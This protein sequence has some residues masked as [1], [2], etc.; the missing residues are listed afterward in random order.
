M[1][2]SWDVIED[3]PTETAAN[4]RG[5]PRKAFLSK[6]AASRIYDMQKQKTL[7]SDL[8]SGRIFYHLLGF[9]DP[10]CLPGAP[11]A[12]AVVMS[13]AMAVS[14]HSKFF[15]GLE[16]TLFLQEIFSVSQFLVFQNS[17]SDQHGEQGRTDVSII[18]DVI[19]Y[20]HFCIFRLKN[21]FSN[22]AK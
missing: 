5:L 14:Q 15:C 7:N 1:V 17:I 2:R 9:H 13:S 6:Q 16:I 19:Y 10:T 22:L 8:V 3:L 12:E 21:S 11:A 20:I 4:A 18:L